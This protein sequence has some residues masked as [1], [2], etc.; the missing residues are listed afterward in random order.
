MLVEQSTKEDIRRFRDK[1]I[2]RCEAA[3]EG[4]MHKKIKAFLQRVC[5]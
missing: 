2:T 1:A 4:W 5:G 3:I